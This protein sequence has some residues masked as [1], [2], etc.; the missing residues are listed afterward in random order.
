MIIQEILK[1]PRR[2]EYL[3]KYPGYEMVISGGVVY[4]KLRKGPAEFQ[5]VDRAQQDWALY[6]ADIVELVEAI[7]EEIIPTKK[8]RNTK[9]SRIDPAELIKERKKKS[10][11][12]LAKEYK[13]SEATIKK[14]I[15]GKR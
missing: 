7:P 12:Q 9:A 8:I 3:Y 4:K 11:K 1:N 2:A 14:I 15:S 13:V 10:I 5:Q 6:T